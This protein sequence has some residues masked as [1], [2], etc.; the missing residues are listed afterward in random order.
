MNE[1]VVFCTVDSEELGE[2]IAAGLVENREAAC[3]NIVS[4]VRSIYRWEGKLC[5]DA[6]LLLIIKSVAE[7]FEAVRERIRRMHTYQVPEVIAVP[8]TAGDADYLEWL[9]ASV[10]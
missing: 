10:I 8:I 5:R 3:V 1:I 7:K 2:K 6:E 4:G 9:R